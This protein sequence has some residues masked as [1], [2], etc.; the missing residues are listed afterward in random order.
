MLGFTEATDCIHFI[1]ANCTWQPATKL[2]FTYM[3]M[4]I[5]TPHHIT[6]STYAILCYVP[7]SR[8]PDATTIRQVRCAPIRSLRSYLLLTAAARTFSH[9]LT[10]LKLT[11]G[12]LIF[13]CIAIVLCRSAAAAFV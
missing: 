3:L 13:A 5:D 2:A 4:S 10:S 12:V 7:W 9:R 1:G 8:P 11:E 6:L